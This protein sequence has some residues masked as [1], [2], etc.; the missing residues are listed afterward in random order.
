MEFSFTPNLENHSPN[1]PAKRPPEDEREEFDL[2]SATL[3]RHAIE[4]LH[5]EPTFSRASS[6][7]SDKSPEELVTV[8]QEMEATH[9]REMAEI[10]NQYANVSYQLEQLMTLLNN[11]FASHLAVIHDVQKVHLNV[12]S[13]SKSHH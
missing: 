6:E 7:I 9:A 12:S 1:F 4:G 5:G 3:K 10:K 8:I 2:Q 13:D 11:H